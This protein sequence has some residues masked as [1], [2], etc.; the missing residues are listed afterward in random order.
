MCRVYFYLFMS[1]S[2]KYLDLPFT[3]QEKF[4]II[5]K[6]GNTTLYIRK[7]NKM[8]KMNWKNNIM[9][10]ILICAM[11]LTGCG[12]GNADPSTAESSSLSSAEETTNETTPS[13]EETTPEESTAQTEST[14]EETE[15]ISETDENGMLL[16]SAFETVEETVYAISNVNLRQSPT[17]EEDNIYDVLGTG[18][19][20]VRTGYRED[21]SIVSYQDQKLYVSS[22]YL[23]TTAPEITP[24]APETTP[25][26][27]ETTPAAVN[28]GSE[29]PTGGNG[30][31]VCID[32]GHQQAGI[33][34]TEPNGPGSSE[35][36]AKLT[37]GTQG[38]ATGKPEYQLNLEVSLLLKQELLNRGYQVVMIRET[39][40]C[41]SSNAERAQTANAS[42]ASIFIRIHANSSTDSSMNGCLTMAPTAANPYVS[43]LAA[44]S[45]SLSQSIVNHICAQT[46]FRNIGVLGTDTMTGINWCTIPVSIVEMGYMSNPDEDT[47]MSDPTYQNLIVQ[48]IANGVDEY[49]ASH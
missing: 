49:F 37:T 21:W 26:A 1:F 11:I 4:Y 24:T 6:I 22:Q 45:Q 19:S 14:P 5:K 38:C 42:G 12:N 8:K 28:P 36:K 44:D 35:M 34:D 40:D 3:N 46:G 25:T 31:I 33:S 18:Q 9:A 20:A 41:P 10:V 47:K 48:G 2:V 15:S 43:Y 13:A 23:T 7:G 30:I 16:D 39:N 27:P 17:T 29:T 32:A